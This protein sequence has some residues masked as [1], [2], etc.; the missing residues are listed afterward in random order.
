MQTHT[1]EAAATLGAALALVAVIHAGIWF[2]LFG[3]PDF[4][5][6]GYPFHYFW[7]VAGGPAAMYLLY[8]VYYQFIT[9]SIVEEKKLLHAEIDSTQR[10]DA[11]HVTTDGGDSRYGENN[12]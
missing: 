3:T 4:T 7:L 8:W 6:L 10:A 5:V 1:K 11:D 2:T 9:T 12:E